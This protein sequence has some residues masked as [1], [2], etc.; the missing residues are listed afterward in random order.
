MFIIWQEVFRIKTAGETRND[1]ARYLLLFSHAKDLDAT[2][3]SAI[4]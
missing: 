4:V 1:I 3:Q 2:K